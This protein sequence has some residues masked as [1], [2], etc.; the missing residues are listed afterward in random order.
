MLGGCTRLPAE[1]GFDFLGCHFE[2]GMNWM[3][4]KSLGK[5]KDTIRVKTK[6]TDGHR[7]QVIIE[8]VS[9]ATEGWFECFEHG[10]AKTFR[11]LDAWIRMRIRSVLRKR[12]CR[13]GRGRGSDH[14]RWPT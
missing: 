3:D 4:Y 2:R 7:R 13:R 6:R 1:R 14:Q 12:Q 5:F 10:Q 8:D 9:R 11:E